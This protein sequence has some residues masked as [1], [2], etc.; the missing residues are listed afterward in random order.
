[1]GRAHSRAWREANRIF[2]LPMEIDCALLVGHDRSRTEAAAAQ[3]GFDRWSLDWREAVE[4]PAIDLV[5]VCA[6]GWLHADI[7]IAALQAGKHVLCEKPLA[8]T[9]AE[10]SSMAKAAEQAL[11]RGVFAMVGFN[12]RRDPGCLPPGLAGRCLCPPYLAPARR[13]DGIRGAR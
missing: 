5:D 2:D 3:L 1:M 10:A 12:Y 13:S 9:L 4:D 11:Y 6:P 7:S 8:N